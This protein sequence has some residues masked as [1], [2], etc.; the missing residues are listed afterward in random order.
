METEAHKGIKNI[1]PEF[2]T[3]GRAIFTVSSTRKH[4]TFKITKKENQPFFVHVLTGKD[5]TNN[6]TYVGCFIPRARNREY[7]KLTGKSRYSYDS[8]I[9]KTFDWAMHIVLQN[10]LVPTGYSIAHAG[11]C[12]TCGRQLTTPA[13]IERGF[14][15]HCFDDL[16]KRQKENA[17][18]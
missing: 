15:P 4:Y 8:Q 6:Y 3:A 2:L 16:S 17:L 7:L 10:L 9:V 14:G 13:S 1:T 11:K 12:G 18:F 5:N